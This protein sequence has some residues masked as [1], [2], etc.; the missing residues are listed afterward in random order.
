MHRQTALVEQT[1]PAEPL[2]HFLTDQVDGITATLESIESWS[3]ENLS[4]YPPTP[5]A[6]RWTASVEPSVEAFCSAIRINPLLPYR[7]YVKQMSERDAG[8]GGPL[9][10]SDLSFLGGGVSQ[11]NAL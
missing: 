10:W 9:N 2:I 7:L 3:T 4:Y 6:L 5:K 1:V 8:L 11:Q